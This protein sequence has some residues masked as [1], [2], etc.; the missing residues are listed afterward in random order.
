MII[1]LL[2]LTIFMYFLAEDRWKWKKSSF[3]LHRERNG[4]CFDVKGNLLLN[5]FTISQFI[6]AV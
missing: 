4:F 6:C 1:S 2:E 3:V 5:L